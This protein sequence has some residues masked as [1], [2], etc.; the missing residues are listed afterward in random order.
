VFVNFLTY[1]PK[2]FYHNIYGNASHILYSKLKLHAICYKRYILKEICVF[3]VF[4]AN[5]CYTF[6]LIE[7]SDYIIRKGMPYE[8]NSS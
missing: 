6:Y 4:F 1:T 8:K 7:I 3:F 2:E 5:M